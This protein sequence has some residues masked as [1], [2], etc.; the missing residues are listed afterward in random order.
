MVD[1]VAAQARLTS[2]R[3]GR[4]ALWAFGGLATLVT[5]YLLAAWIGSSLPVNRGWEEAADGVE[6]MVETNGLHTG[7]VLPIVTPEMDWRTIFPS[8]VQPV[9]SG[10]MPTHIAVGWGEREV[11]LNTP[12]WADLDPLTALRILTT[13]GTGLMRV[14]H[15]VRPTPS[16]YHRPLKLRP[17]EYRRLVR[18]ILRTMPPAA[19][20]ARRSVYLSYEP[21]AVHHDAL[22]RYTPVDTCNTWVGEALAYAGVRTGRWT[23]LAGGVMKWVE[24]P[25]RQD[26]MVSH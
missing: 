15:Y 26:S 9:R 22:G 11:F 13:G 24:E 20:Q 17:A 6:I 12:Y 21:D 8:A 18:F 3:V 4:A 19:D 7:L 23:P 14:A 25:T 16:E 1:T 10:R 2:R 5:A